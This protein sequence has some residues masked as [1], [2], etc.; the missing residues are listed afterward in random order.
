MR[1]P[2]SFPLMWKSYWTNELTNGEI[3]NFQMSS[4]LRSKNAIR[5]YN[6]K[7]MFR[8]LHMAY[9]HGRVTTLSFNVPS[10]MKWIRIHVDAME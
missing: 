2:H 1:A 6:I 8:S 7:S 9:P 10:N 5:K 4:L 3:Q